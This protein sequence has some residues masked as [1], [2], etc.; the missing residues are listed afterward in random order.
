MT[1]LQALASYFR[2][3]STRYR[4][5]TAESYRRVLL[6]F[7]EAFGRRHLTAIKPEEIEEWLIAQHGGRWQPATYNAT[8]SA[9]RSFWRW[10]ARSGHIRYDPT[11]RLETRR[12]PHHLPRVADAHDV[13]RI[14]AG[15]WTDS[16]RD[17]RDKAVLEL[18][19]AAGLRASELCRLR[20]D[21]LNFDRKEVR[22]R[23]GKGGHEGVVPFNRPATRALMDYLGYARPVLLGSRNSNILF[24]SDRG[25]D[26]RYGHLAAIFSRAKRRAGIARPLTAHRLRGRVA[27]D[28]LDGGAESR[29]VQEFLRHKYL[30]S[31]QRYLAVSPKRLHEVYAKAHPRA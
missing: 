23:D 1:V 8:L 16:P 3:S 11:S 19:L 21:D 24:I 14:L 5:G 29:Y 10:A 31:T 25:E 12:V 6:K 20:L 15:P 2:Y 9:L 18:F 22:V 4:P 30:S 13:A 28:L 17:L 26:F 27:T 7:S